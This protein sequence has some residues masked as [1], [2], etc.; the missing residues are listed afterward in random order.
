MATPRRCSTRL[1]RGHPLLRIL[2]L[3]LVSFW[4]GTTAE[5]IGCQRGSFVQYS[6]FSRDYFNDL[7][8]GVA[9]FQSVRQT[10]ISCFFVSDHSWV[11]LA[12]FRGTA[13]L[14]RITSLASY[15]IALVFF[16]KKYIYIKC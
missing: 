9:A 14:S 12:R 8:G 7:S 15:E 4:D 5:N 2:L 13:D 1:R 3:A 16:L 6:S 11:L 10:T